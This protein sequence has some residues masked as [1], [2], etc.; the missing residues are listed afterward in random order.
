[1]EA[2]RQPRG[3]SRP[4]DTEGRLP[5][6]GGEGSGSDELERPAGQDWLVGCLWWGGDGRDQ[7]GASLSPHPHPLQP[8]D[9]A[10][11]SFPSGHL[12]EG[13]RTL[14]SIARGPQGCSLVCSEAW[15]LGPEGL[16]P[17]LP[18]LSSSCTHTRTQFTA[19]LWEGSLQQ[20]QR[21]SR[22]RARGADC[23]VVQGGEAASA[24][25]H[26]PPPALAVSTPPSRLLQ[27]FPQDPGFSAGGSFVSLGNIWKRFWLS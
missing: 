1:M 17:S 25:F 18:S 7:A 11:E 26:I 15:D 16:S 3:D 19:A 22:D 21:V 5:N 20:R 24:A 2:G 13:Q 8:G 10:T 23:G 12:V 4:P 14:D 9:G 6:Q 27:H